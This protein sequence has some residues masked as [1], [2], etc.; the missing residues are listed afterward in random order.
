MAERATHNTTGR[1]QDAVEF[2][3]DHLSAAADFARK[4]GGLERARGL[5]EY[6]VSTQG[7]NPMHREGLD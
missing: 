6:L 7:S 1:K 4:V 5:I 2:S 3:Q